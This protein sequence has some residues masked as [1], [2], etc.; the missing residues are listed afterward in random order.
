LRKLKSDFPNAEITWITYSV[1]VI[2]LGWVDN[3]LEFS[4]TNVLWLEQQHF[5][6]LINLDKD[7]EAIALAERITATK[8]SG[9][10]MNQYGKCIPMG[11]PSEEH[12]W[13]TG[14]W[15]DLNQANTMNYMEEIFLICGY[16]F[17]GE[18]YILDVE[19]QLA[20]QTKDVSKIVVGLNTGCGARWTTRLWPDDR[21]AELATALMTLGYDT[22][23]LG[24]PQEDEKN[25]RLAQLSGA[26]YFGTTSLH[27]F[28]SLINKCDVIVSQV[29]MAMHVAIALKRYL[30]LLNNIFNR[31]EFYLYDRGVIIQPDLDCLGCFKQTFDQ[32]CKST[33]CMEMI[34]VSD[35][36]TCIRSRFP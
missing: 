7:R 26:D 33:N 30:V 3:I 18:E 22:V 16:T 10:R 35:V 5:D 29:T 34:G 19:N 8:K 4:F 12:K 20:S 32:N 25:K 9:F 1:E 21:W 17:N 11:H 13:L 28:F 23:L 6:W 27:Q 31:N 15:D 2:P 14:V 24:G 36:I